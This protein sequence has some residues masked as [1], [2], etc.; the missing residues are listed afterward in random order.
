MDYRTLQ[1]IKD[2]WQKWRSSR[3]LILLIV[4]IALFLDNM[5]LTTVGK[6]KKNSI[7]VFYRFFFFN[8]VPIVPDYLY[9]L[10]QLTKPTEDTFKFLAKNCSNDEIIKHRNYFGRQPVQFRRILRTYCNWTVDWAINKTDLENKQRT[11]VLE[12]VGLVIRR[13]EKFEFIFF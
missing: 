13:R 4:F 2:F 8:E 9:N 7:L 12:K 5:L 1:C 3:V 6:S 11:I 10:Q